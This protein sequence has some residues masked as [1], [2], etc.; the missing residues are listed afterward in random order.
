MLFYDSHEHAQVRHFNDVFVLKPV[1]DTTELLMKLA[2]E[3]DWLQTNAF[4]LYYHDDRL[5]LCKA[6]D[7]RGVWVRLNDITRRL[8]GEFSLA[9]ACGSKKGSTLDVLDVTAGL[10]IDALALRA[11]GNRL[12]LTEREPILWALLSDLLRR[13]DAADVRLHHTDAKPILAEQASFDVV[14]MDPMFP[15]RRKSA[16]PNKRMQYLSELLDEPVD[17]NLADFVAQARRVARNRVVLKRRLRDPQVLVPDWQIR[18]KTIR[19][20]IFRGSRNTA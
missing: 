17:E 6:G 2:V 11:R 16:L 19:Y 18:G 14:Y 5:M 1:V 10:G 9:K 12:T 7:T 3:G 15:Q 13:A 8:Q 4:Y 20:D